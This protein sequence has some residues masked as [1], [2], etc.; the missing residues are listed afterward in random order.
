MWPLINSW[1]LHL[2]NPFLPTIN[3]YPDFLELYFI[4]LQCQQND[5]L[6]VVGGH[7]GS[8]FVLKILTFGS[9]GTFQ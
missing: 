9:V 8:T 7:Y 5:A 4:A 1:I 2:K 6:L 3:K